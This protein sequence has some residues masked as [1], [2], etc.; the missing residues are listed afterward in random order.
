MKTKTLLL[1]VLLSISLSAQLPNTLTPAE[2]IYGLSKFWQEVNYNFIFLEKTG[3]AKWDSIY[4]EFIPIVLKTENDYKYFRELERFCALLND[5]HTNIYMPQKKEFERMNTMF[6]EYRL[7]L[8]NI[9]NKA[10]VTGTNFSKKDEIPVGSEIIE[11]N[12]LATK[13]YIKQFV[14]PYISSSTDYVL[15]DW[16]IG[17]LLQGFDG[18]SY[19]VKIKRPKGD[20]I[21]LKLTH[22]QTKEKETFPPADTTEYGLLDFEWKEKQIAYVSLNGFGDKKIDSLWVTK[23]PELY[24]AKGLIIDLRYNGGGST[25]IGAEIMQYLTNDKVIYGSKSVTRSHNAAYKAWGTYITVKDTLEDKS[26]WSGKSYL[27]A[28]DKSYYTFEYEPDSVK[29]SAKRIVIPTAILIGHNTASAAED[30]LIYA[31]NQKHMVKIGAN[32]FGSTGQPYSFELVGGARARVCTKKDTYPDG[33]EFIGYGIK[34]DI[35]VSPTVN[36]YLLKKDPVL[37]KAVEYLKTKIK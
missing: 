10:I 9:D 28:N 27:S 26:G 3:K 12:G 11:V 33:R 30:F 17:R 6:G 19:N 1:F 34:P 20:I 13:D 21:S 36:D 22:S 25:G 15:M 24:K 8:K 23:L 2:K 18:D 29:L 16:S 35:M 14:S 32:T 7:F 37:D 4:R 5:G 31:D